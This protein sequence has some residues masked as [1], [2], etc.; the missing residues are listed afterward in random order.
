MSVS[1]KLKRYNLGENQ[2]LM[3]LIE[4]IAGSFHAL[5]PGIY[6][7]ILVCEIF[8]ASTG[9][10]FVQYFVGEM[11][12]VHRFPFVCYSTLISNSNSVCDW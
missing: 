12:H 4:V 10:F 3:L 11:S 7:F 9:V 2:I 1:C 8:R 5:S 6:P